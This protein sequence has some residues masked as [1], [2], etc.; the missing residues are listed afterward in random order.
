M[1]FPAEPSKP[2]EPVTRLGLKAEEEAIPLYDI[3]TI[4]AAPL[5]GMPVDE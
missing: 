3:E 1:I 2:G 4:Y 5:D